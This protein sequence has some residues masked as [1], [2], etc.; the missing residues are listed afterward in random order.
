MPNRAPLA[1]PLGR[2]VRML[3][4][5][6]VVVT[7]ACSYQPPRLASA[8]PVTTAA[9]AAGGSTA[10]AAGLGPT[11]TSAP[12]TSAAPATA[13]GWGVVDGAGTIVATAR[14][15]LSGIAVFGSPGGSRVRTLENPSAEYGV[16]QVFVVTERQPGWLKVMLPVRPNG[17]TGWIRESDVTLAAHDYRIVVSLSGHRFALFRAGRLVLE[18]PA[19][20][21]RSDRP[22][23][24]GT[25]YTWVLLD[26]TQ[27]IYG[28]YAYG[29]SGFSD[30]VTSFNG[31]PGRL[32]IHGT[33]DPSSI[34]RDVSSGCIRLSNETVTRLVRSIG[35]PLGVPV[36]V[37]A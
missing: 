12:G 37:R 15:G 10:P 24:G 1:R 34:G 13:A 23:P 33:N 9:P 29:L 2:A 17:T 14:S 6:V 35:L 4:G 7:A 30:V 31:G 22:T 27:D 25:Y 28:A 18:A 32:G 19:G 36:E 5:L 3:A 26:P 20:I 11:S 16:N 21:G 8:P